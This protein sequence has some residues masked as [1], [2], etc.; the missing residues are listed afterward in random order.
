MAIVVFQNQDKEQTANNTD[1]RN[2]VILLY[3]TCSLVVAPVV[4]TLAFTLEQVPEI[5]F[6]LEPDISIPRK[7]HNSMQLFWRVKQAKE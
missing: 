4:C 7:V 5:D 1:A 2:R 6:P 3:S